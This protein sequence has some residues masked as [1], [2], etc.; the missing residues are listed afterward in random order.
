MFLEGVPEFPASR[1]ISLSDRSL[2]ES[3]FARHP[4]E[5]SERTFG[6]IYIWRT[7]EGRSDISQLD[8][9]LLIFWYKARF[10]RT[11]LPPVG[12]D[13]AG[14]VESLLAHKGF[15]NLGF[16]GVYGLTEP[17]VSQLAAT[18][19]KLESLRD[20]WDYV[21]RTEDLIR[22]EGPK[23][24]TQRKEL[25]KATSQYELVFEPMTQEHREACLELQETWCDMKRCTLDKLSSAEDRALKDALDNLKELGFF[26]GVA[27]IDGKIQAL[28]IGEGLDQRTSVVHFEKANPAIRGLY[29][30]IN[31]EFCR[32]LLNGRE[33]VN[34]EQDVGEAGLRRA[35][36]GYHP[37]HFV[38]KHILLRDVKGL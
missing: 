26:G 2:I 15:R 21:Y 38:E 33:F 11:L 8:G 31:Q 10:G 36:E 20:E 30:F 17:Q 13:P 32:N 1:P 3:L 28:T 6:S 23:Y 14:S 19:R 16:T 7:Y 29:Q 18:G 4:S 12:P 24:H 37:H 35:K 25:A 5:L 27:I 34:R 22:L 9:H